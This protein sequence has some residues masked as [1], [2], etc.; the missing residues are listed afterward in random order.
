M[1][2][3]AR[4]QALGR[5]TRSTGCRGAASVRQG[6]GKCTGAGARRQAR[7]Q[8]AW[9]RGAWHWGAE[10]HGRSAGKR[11]AR[12]GGRS[13]HAAGPVG[14]ALGALSLFLARFDS[15]LFLSKF[16]DIVHEPGS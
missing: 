9:A 1:R 6:R 8:A 12:Q 4:R 2:K 15:V 3:W 7:A 11:G 5:G 13:G 16:L 10:R 14:C